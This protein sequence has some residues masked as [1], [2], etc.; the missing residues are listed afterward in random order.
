MEK[1]WRGIGDMS[2]SKPMVAL[3]IDALLHRRGP[4]YWHDLVDIM[5]L[6][7]SHIHCFI[8]DVMTRLYFSFVVLLDRRG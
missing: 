2:L 6:L 7:S 1:G 5:A 8:W 3:I 4:F